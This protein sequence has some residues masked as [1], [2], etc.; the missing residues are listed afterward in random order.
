MGR[1]RLGVWGVAPCA[2]VAG[3]TAEPSEDDLLESGEA[4]YSQ[5][6]EE[7]VIRHFIGD[8][9]DGVFLDVGS[10][11]WKKLSTTLYLEK[12]LGWTGFAID[13]FGPGYAENRPGTK[14]LA[15]IVTDH[16]GSSMTF[17]IAEGA[18]GAASVSKKWIQDFL[19]GFPARPISN[20]F[21]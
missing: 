7:L 11:H 6:N 2:L 4:L 5:G 20:L 9:R 3:C 1:I 14:F 13:A 8:R 10:Y 18:E 19:A 12:H 21:R 16:S 15:Y 17:Y